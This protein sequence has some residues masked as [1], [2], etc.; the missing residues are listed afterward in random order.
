MSEYTTELTSELRSRG[1]A[2]AEIADILIELPA[3][4]DEDLKREFGEAKAYAAS[5]PKGAKRS[6]GHKIIAAT[7]AIGLAVVVGRLFAV[8]FGVR[9]GSVVELLLFLGGLVVAVAIASI[10]GAAVD[11][12]PIKTVR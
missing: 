10:V 3:C 11:R 4:A 5:F 7:L 6:R 8:L 9:D 12:R 2:E 1:I